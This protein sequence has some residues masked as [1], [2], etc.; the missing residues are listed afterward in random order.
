MPRWRIGHI[1]QVWP[2]SI[3]GRYAEYSTHMCAEDLKALWTSILKTGCLLSKGISSRLYS[4]ASRPKIWTSQYQLLHA[5]L[6][7]Q[8]PWISSAYYLLLP[9]GPWQV[10]EGVSTSFLHS[11]WQSIVQDPLHNLLFFLKITMW[12][13]GGE[14][15]SAVRIVT[16]YTY[17]EGARQTCTNRLSI[18]SSVCVNNGSLHCSYTH[19]RVHTTI[20]IGSVYLALYL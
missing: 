9:H 19:T 15:N 20:Y 13:C 8:V 16:W 10:G 2:P 14:C 5:H 4:H 11:K 6:T 7:C 18:K 1:T 3:S 17:K 12:S